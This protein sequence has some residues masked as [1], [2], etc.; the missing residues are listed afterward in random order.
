METKTEVSMAK[1]CFIRVKICFRVRVKVRH[2]VVKDR[3]RVMARV[4]L[5]LAITLAITL[6]RHNAECIMSMNCPH[7]DSDICACMSV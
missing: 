5:T 6:M 4:T 3:A 2:S 7:C 1:D